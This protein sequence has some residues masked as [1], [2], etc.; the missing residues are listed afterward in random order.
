MTK[1]R[2][3]LFQFLT[4][5]DLVDYIEVFNW[6]YQCLKCAKE[7]QERNEEILKH[8]RQVIDHAQ[9]VNAECEM[10]LDRCKEVNE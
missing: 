2:K 8:T 7:C 4:G 9:K 6:G 5:Y 10:L 1:F 3:W